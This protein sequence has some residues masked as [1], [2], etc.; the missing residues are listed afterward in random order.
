MQIASSP[1][2]DADAPLCTH[3]RVRFPN[4]DSRYPLLQLSYEHRSPSHTHTHTQRHR[5]AHTHARTQK[6]RGFQENKR[7][8][9]TLLALHTGNYHC[10]LPNEKQSSVITCVA[11]AIARCDAILQRQNRTAHLCIC[12][13]CIRND[14]GRANSDK[15]DVSAA[16]SHMASGAWQAK[17]GRVAASLEWQHAP[18]QE[19]KLLPQEALCPSSLRSHEMLV[20]PSSAGQY[21]LSHVSAHTPSV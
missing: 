21:P 1:A 16:Q 18:L 7:P 13:R 14:G 5:H 4:D 9:R 12:P 10:P 17:A 11:L 6:C 20:D 2:Q 19:A 3:S 15:R 8:N